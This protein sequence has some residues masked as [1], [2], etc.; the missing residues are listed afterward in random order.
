MSKKF[1]SAYPARNNARRTPAPSQAARER[2]RKRLAA[3]QAQPKPSHSKGPRIDC[4]IVDGPTRKQLF[5]ENERCR[6]SDGEKQFH[7]AFTIK[8]LGHE[9]YCH[10]CIT[11]IDC[12][13]YS[14]FNLGGEIFCRLLTDRKNERHEFTCHYYLIG[15]H[16]RMRIYVDPVPAPKSKPSP[17]ASST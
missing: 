4:T 12:R 11:R 2:A 13:D 14:S 8:Y 15:D 9:Q 17:A 6:N 16:G 1:R 5:R 7:A 10:A 3:A